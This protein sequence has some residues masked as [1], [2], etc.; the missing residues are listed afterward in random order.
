[1]I[2]GLFDA[3]SAREELAT[4]HVLTALRESV[5]L[6]RT[7]DEQIGRLRA[8]ADGR[9]RNASGVSTESNQ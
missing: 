3:F 6:A 1:M 8:W 9:A 5:P 4:G 7:M 2:S